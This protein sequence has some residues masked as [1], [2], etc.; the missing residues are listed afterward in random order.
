MEDSYNTVR[1]LFQKKLGNCWPFDSEN[2]PNK[3]VTSI[4]SQNYCST[5]LRVGK[6]LFPDGPV[7]AKKHHKKTFQGQIYFLEH[8]GTKMVVKSSK[9]LT[10]RS[11]NWFNL[12]SSSLASI[13]FLSP[14]FL[15]SWVY[16]T[17]SQLYEKNKLIHIPACYYTGLT[18]LSQKKFEDA[19]E[20]IRADAHK[21]LHMDLPTIRKRKKD[22]DDD[23]L[24]DD[25]KRKL[26]DMI[27][28]QMDK[29][30]R[31]PSESNLCQLVVLEHLQSDVPTVLFG[32]KDYRIWFSIMCQVTLALCYFQNNFGLIHNDLYC[33]NVR[34]R[35]VEKDTVLYY[36]LK[37]LDMYIKVPT[38]GNVAVIIDFGRVYLD[39]DGKKFVSNDFESEGPKPTKKPF[40][41]PSIDLIRFVLSMEVTDRFDSIRDAKKGK[42]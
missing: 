29:K 30:K 2:Y 32:E 28:N 1:R 12:S 13:W 23:D 42:S 15:E 21:K 39:F 33:D 5:K 38:F 3:I 10:N 4:D 17:F 14:A 25:K 36:Y 7:V 11:K 40:D 41:N 20:V 16:A 34:I 22:E 27:M 8:H 26:N 35:K 31:N 37:S 19:Y 6:R 24:E 18:K 9:L